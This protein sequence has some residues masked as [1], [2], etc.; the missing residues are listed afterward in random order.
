MAD[1]PVV[2]GSSPSSPRQL[3][4][5]VPFA[6]V[7]GTAVGR[8][9]G[10]QL[11]PALAAGSYHW[12][13]AFG[14]D[15]LSTAQVYATC[16]RLRA[17]ARSAAGD[18][19]RARRAEL[20]HPLMTAL[21]SGDP[22]AVGPLLTNDLQPAALS[23]QPELRR[24]LTRGPRARRARRDRVGLRAD[25]RV[26]GRDAA[27][28]P[29][30]R[31]RAHRLGRL[32]RGRAGPAA[33]RRAPCVVRTGPGP[34][35]VVNLVNLEAAAKAYHERVLLDRVSLGVAAGQRIGVVGRNGAGKTTLL[36]ALAGT[37]DLDSGRIDQGA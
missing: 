37:A 7:G 20:S 26:P 6:L 2:S 4:S 27:Q 32:P 28:R 13:L 15:G 24:A 31:R 29:R 35:A 30:A 12:A 19:R 10:E 17:A 22:A 34:P 5:D 23:L 9:R 1:R 21:R 25:L 11:T 18:Q 14:H 36:A 33:R 3:G 8:G 16:D